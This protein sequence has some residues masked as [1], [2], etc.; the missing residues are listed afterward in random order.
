MPAPE[1]SIP[2]ASAWRAHL[3]ALATA[4]GLFALGLYAFILV[5]DPY[6]NVPFS[7]PLPR[8]PV[9]TN[10]RFS[11][12][13]IARNP[14]FDSAVF[15]TST[16]RLLN[17]DHLNPLLHAKFANLAMNGA[18]AWEQSQIAGLFVRH[19]PRARFLVLGVDAMWC[20]TGATYQRTTFRFFPEWMYDDNR[21]NDLLYL[22]NDKVLEQAVREVEYLQ[23]KRRAKYRRD[24]YRY[25]LPA[26]SRWD[27]AKARTKIYG[28]ADV[29]PAALA[30]AP[31]APATRLDP[32][33][34]FPAHPLLDGL[35]GAA[36]R[37]TAKVIV[38]V[39]YHEHM[40]RSEAVLYGECKGRIV[41][42]AARHGNTHVVD[43]MIRSPI[44]GNDENYWD[45]LHFRKSV[46]RLVE[47]SIATAVVERRDA[48]GVYRYLRPANVRRAAP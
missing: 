27:L 36:A 21:W 39:P 41:D 4:L 37:E 35:L 45:A 22:F 3:R 18:T 25:F 31:D 40:L 16:A 42:I 5:V 33:L 32:S 34:Y 38:F 13:P 19:H 24:G 11:Y 23:G 30:P 28:S 46:G 9:D 14:A 29:D 17:P 1:S 20:A 8:A 48:P 6:Q 2:D 10:Q 47:R 15:G 26:E 43:F 12:P 7:P 44:T